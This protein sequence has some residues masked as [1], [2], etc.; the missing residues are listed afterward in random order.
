MRVKIFVFLMVFFTG[1]SIVP[2][3]W[4]AEEGGV[5]GEFGVSARV[6]SVY[7]GDTITVVAEPWPGHFVET[8]VRLAGVDT[9]EIRGRCEAEEDLALVARGRLVELVGDS[10]VGSLKV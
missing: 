2:F 6:I 3:L 1:F 9:P 10:E 8:R 7:D 5:V 4:V